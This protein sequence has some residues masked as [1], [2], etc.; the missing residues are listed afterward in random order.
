MRFDGS[1]GRRPQSEAR[2]Y[3]YRVLAMAIE[4]DGDEMRGWLLGG[5]ENE[6]DRRRVKKAAKVVTKELRRKA[7]AT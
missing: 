7:D 5:L 3:V 2:R 1:S 6:A 4:Y